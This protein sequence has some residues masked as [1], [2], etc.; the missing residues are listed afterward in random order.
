MVTLPQSL[1]TIKFQGFRARATLKWFADARR[2]K[3]PRSCP[4][5]ASSFVVAMNSEKSLNNE[6]NYEYEEISGNTRVWNIHLPGGG[7]TTSDQ[8]GYG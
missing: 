8:T 3:F 1:S 6:M 2:K 7:A 4:K 5:W